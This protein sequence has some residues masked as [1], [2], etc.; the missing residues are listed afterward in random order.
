MEGGSGG[1]VQKFDAWR[2]V[3]ITFTD[4]NGSTVTSPRR[5]GERRDFAARPQTPPARSASLFSIASHLRCS[6]TSSTGRS[7]TDATARWAQAVG[8]GTMPSSL[9]ASGGTLYIA[10]AGRSDA[11]SVF[12]LDGGFRGVPGRRERHDRRPRD[13]L[14]GTP[15]GAP[16]RSR[17]HSAVAR[18]ARRSRNAERSSPARSGPERADALA[19]GSRRP[20]TPCLTG[21][22]SGSSRSRATHSTGVRAIGPASPSGA[23][24][25][26]C[27]TSSE[28]TT[29]AR[30]RSTGGAPDRGTRRTFSR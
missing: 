27:R 16:R 11:C 4:T 2:R 8:V 20:S 21:R 3:D 17:E 24:G 7:T 19:S 1:R 9:A 13:R 26:S 12:G 22:T 28:P 14:R 5:T 10:D 6:S 18:A 30:P 15:A 23:M 29:P 25:P